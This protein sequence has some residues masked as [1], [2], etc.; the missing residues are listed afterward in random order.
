MKPSDQIVLPDRQ[1][2]PEA[3][4]VPTQHDGRLNRALTRVSGAPLRRGN[5]IDL[6]R[7]GPTTYEDWLAAIG[8]AQRWVH[9]EN[10]IFKDD[11]IGKRFAEA[12]I[13]RAAAGVAVRVLYDWFGS[14][15]V[16]PRFW[17]RMRQ[18]GVDVRAVNAVFNGAPL[19]I[20]QRDHRKLVAVDGIYA[21]VG[22]VCI[23]DPWL[24]KSP[25]SGLP[26]RDT[27]VRVSGP[28][29]ADL[30]RAFATVWDSVGPPLPDGELPAV[31]GIA[32][33]GAVAARVVAE[34]P[35]R[36]R[37]L[38]VLQLALAAA[39]RRVWIADAYF[40]GAQSLREALIAA[41]V[42]GV[43]VRILLPATN[44]LPLV[45]ALSRYGYRPLLKSGVRI[46][47]YTG[48]MMHAKTTVADG[49]WARIGS[50]NLNV[51]GL[52]TNWELDLVAED[53]QFAA[54]MEAMYEED[55]A[56]SREIRLGGSPRRMRPRPDRPE[57]RAERYDRTHRP[58]V[59][60]LLWAAIA[61]VRAAF[62]AATTDTL[63]QHERTVGAAIGATLLSLSVL[64]ARF[65]RLLAW[66]LAA[67]GGLF[68]AVSLV[69][70]AGPVEPAE[71]PPRRDGRFARSR[72]A[73]RKPRRR[74]RGIRRRG[75]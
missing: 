54:L 48:L 9:L 43:D 52:L 50:T 13:E 6:L 47:E 27:A 64:S 11:G 66:P 55:L 38:R 16:S 4:L 20:V 12:L 22:G 31:A 15:D 72:E 1:A 45:G 30:E 25:E 60:S 37:M 28:V 34:E 74:P 5:A 10:Y 65:P 24:S 61:R 35:R 32:P 56:H 58:F 14:L 8:R 33:A 75:T 39:E 62:G 23:A 59:R 69:R 7:N 41:A 57:S 49:W 21:S 44:D 68:G 19:D 73:L 17:S 26:Y 29:V 70:A 40:L 2:L 67:I 71:P 42:D 63:Q 53:R 18:A 3:M 51:T 36:M 46:W